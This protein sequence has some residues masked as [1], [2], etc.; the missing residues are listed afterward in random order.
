MEENEK[1]NDL[2]PYTYFIPQV[3]QRRGVLF[4]NKPIIPYDFYIKL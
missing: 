3:V 1:I 4:S 2:Y